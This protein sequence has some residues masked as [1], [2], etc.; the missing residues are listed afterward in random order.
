MV[1]GG[2]NMADGEEVSVKTYMCRMYV[3]EATMSG[4][5]INKRSLE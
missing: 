3:D 2:I 5:L 4:L 1:L